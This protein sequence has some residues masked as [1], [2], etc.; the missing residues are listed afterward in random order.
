MLEFL[1]SGETRVVRR[2]RTLH[3]RPRSVV[4]TLIKYGYVI[5]REKIITV[6][7]PS[8]GGGKTIA[9]STTLSSPT[10][11]TTYA[12][13]STSPSSRPRHA[14]P[15]PSPDTSATTL[16]TAGLPQ[17]APDLTSSARTGQAQAR[18]QASQ[19]DYS[20]HVRSTL[21]S[22]PSWRRLGHRKSSRPWRPR[23]PLAI[24]LSRARPHLARPEHRRTLERNQRSPRHLCSVHV[25]RRVPKVHYPHV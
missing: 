16:A 2:P 13:E 24:H 12:P 10:S 15:T 23:Q 25:R 20:P 1:C 5:E 4:H 7:T 21:G 3:S 17:F 6:V 9:Y 8:T 14:V 22:A 19:R 11:T 18:A